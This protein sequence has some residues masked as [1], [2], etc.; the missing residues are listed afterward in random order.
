MKKL[1]LLLSM[2]CVLGGCQRKESIETS[3]Y[4]NETIEDNF[5]VIRG[6]DKHVTVGIHEIVFKDGTKC[7]TVYANGITC[8][9]RH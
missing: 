6:K 8:D 3:N 5:T 7:V 1:A 9:W 2:V 4:K